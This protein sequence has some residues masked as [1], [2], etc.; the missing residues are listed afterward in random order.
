MFWQS[1]A[2][3]LRF[4]KQIVMKIIH[5]ADWHIGQNFY[6]YDRQDEHNHFFDQ[7]VDIV[8]REQ[9]DAL[10]VSGDIYDT[11][12]PSNASVRLYTD[13][14]VRLHQCCPAMR[15]VVTAGNHDSCARLESNGSIWLIANLNVIGSIGYDA[16]SGTF[17][18]NRNIIELPG[19]GYIIA[20]PYINERYHA[21]FSQLQDEVLQRNTDGLPVV[22]MGHLA[23][24]GCDIQGHKFD[25]I[26]GI[27]NMQISTFG[28]AYDYF[29]LGHIHR[30]QTLADGHGRVRYSGSPIHVSFDE[31]YPHTVSIVEIEK[32]GA[33]PIIREERIHQLM[34]TYTVPKEALPFDE[35]LAEL[36]HFKP[37]EPGYVRLNIKVKDYAPTNA[38]RRIGEVLQDKSELKLC[39]IHTEREKQIGKAEKPQWNLEQIKEINPMEIAMAVYRERFGH[40][41]DS[42]KQEMMKSIIEEVTR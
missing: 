14:M 7:L 36:S 38:E 8:V 31:A 19:V 10:L 30:P 16:E 42:E 21:I 41:M 20:I 5:T 1:E 34:H 26:G 37:N 11:A 18:V 4:E 3:I 2:F 33:M 39:Y 15:I 35:A 32:R 23:V 12:T 28:S 9:P 24:S 22:V 17:D 6:H 27:E 40:D 29:A 13:N 25:V